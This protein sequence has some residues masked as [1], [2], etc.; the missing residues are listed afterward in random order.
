VLHP[1]CCPLVVRRTQSTSELRSHS[2]TQLRLR[3][4]RSRE[5]KI[6]RS[7]SRSKGEKA[8]LQCSGVQAEYSGVRVEYKWSAAE[9]SGVQRS[10]VEYVKHGGVLEY[11]SLAFSPMSRSH[12]KNIFGVSIGVTREKNLYG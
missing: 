5:K 10:T 4:S 3:Q 8:R 12:E 9:Y 11:R 2:E 6:C 1:K 7:R